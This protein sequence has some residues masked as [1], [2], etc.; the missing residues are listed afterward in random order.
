MDMNLPS[1]FQRDLNYAKVE[2]N[3]TKKGTEIYPWLY[4]T[5]AITTKTTTKIR[6]AEIKRARERRKNIL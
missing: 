2:E 4:G 1:Q 6:R 5:N 3:A